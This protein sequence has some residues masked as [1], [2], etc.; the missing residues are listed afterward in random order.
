MVKFVLR[1][2]HYASTFKFAYM[3][4]IW[5]KLSIS[6]SS[7][8]SLSRSSVAFLFDSRRHIKTTVTSTEIATLTPISIGNS[9]P[10]IVRLY[11]K[12]G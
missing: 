11:V 6:S 12:F 1:F 3:S 4:P 8:S 9:E 7:S 5:S 10:V 2:V